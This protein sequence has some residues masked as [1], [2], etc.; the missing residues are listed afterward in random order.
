M[1]KIRKLVALAVPGSGA[2]PAESST[3]KAMSLKLMA[4]HDLTPADFRAPAV[5]DWGRERVER[6]AR[7][8]ATR[9]D[10]DVKFDNGS[11]FTMGSMDSDGGI[12]IRFSF[13]C[14]SY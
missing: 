5:R 2:T 6:W 11:S 14:D 1:T 12:N 10:S 7:N 13:G 9:R 3:A 8:S 4:E